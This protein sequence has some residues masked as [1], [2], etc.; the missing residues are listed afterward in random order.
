[1]WGVPMFFSKFFDWVSQLG[2]ANM[3]PRDV[4]YLFEG[5]GASWFPV[6]FPN[7]SHQIPLV[8]I[9]ISSK[10]FCS[11]QVPKK[12]PSNSSCSLQVSNKFILFHQAP[13]KFLLFPSITHQCA[14]VLIKFP[15]NS[16]QIPLVPISILLFSSSSQTIPIKFLFVPMAMEDRQVSTKVNGETRARRGQSAKTE[17]HNSWAARKGEPQWQADV[18]QV[19]QSRNSGFSACQLLW[20]ITGASASR[21]SLLEKERGSQKQRFFLLAK[22]RQ[23]AKLKIRKKNWFW[24]FS[25]ARS[26]GKKN[27]NEETTIARLVNWSHCVAKNIEG[28]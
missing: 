18:C 1:M 3:P 15:N 8:P 17:R 11:H 28:W 5:V 21:A 9:T 22:F 2:G 25:V 6:K 13:I 20:K 27:K 19:W 4:S 26:E 24:R 23:K 14:F 10:F 12:F 7:S 16:H